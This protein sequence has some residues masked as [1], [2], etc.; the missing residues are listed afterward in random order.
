MKNFEHH[1]CRTCG[2][3]HEYY[4]DVDCIGAILY[5]EDGD[6]EYWE[7]VPKQYISS[8]ISGALCI[9]PR[10]GCFAGGG[11]TYGL[12]HAD[13]TCYRATI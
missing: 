2:S 13:P 3:V 9:G 10:C 6:E 7:D 11:P 4:T 12:I 1:R 5:V 8:S